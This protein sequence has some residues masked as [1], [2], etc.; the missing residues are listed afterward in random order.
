MDIAY[1]ETPSRSA[2]SR[3]KVHAQ[4]ATIV[5]GT[6]SSSSL[7]SEAECVEM[8]LSAATTTTGVTGTAEPATLTGDDTITSLHY[9]TRV[10]EVR[11]SS[12]SSGSR[13]PAYLNRKLSMSSK[14]QLFTDIISD[15]SLDEQTSDHKGSEAPKSEASNIREA[16]EGDEAMVAG[17]IAWNETIGKY[18]DVDQISSNEN[19][20]GR[21]YSFVERDS[22]DNG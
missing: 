11:S 2:D 10:A 1:D 8:L 5:S 18:G 14:S 6:S 4:F 15:D 21:N 3:V 20:D 12:S 9:T 13:R 17:G 16:G 7:D 22:L 19:S